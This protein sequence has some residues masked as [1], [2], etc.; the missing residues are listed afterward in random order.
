M[1]TFARAKTQAACAARALAAHGQ[2][3]RELRGTEKINS[4]GTE[5][6]TA[7]ALAGVAR[8]MQAQGWR[9]AVN[10]I[11]ARQAYHFL[12]A[13]AQ[14]VTQ[15]TLDKERRA[16]ERVLSRSLERI[17][18]T[19]QAGRLGVQ[20]R[21]YT[22]AQIEMIANAQ[23]ESNAI[24]TRLAFASGLRACEL[25][26]L[27]RVDELP[28][29][30]RARRR[31][32]LH[33]GR[34]GVVMAVVGKGGLVRH[35]VVPHD[36]VAQLEA[37][38]LDAP[39][40]VHDRGVERFQR[41]AIGAGNSWSK[42]FSDASTRVLGWSVG[43][44]TARHDFARERM[45]ELQALHRYSERDAKEIVAQEVGHWSARTTDTYLR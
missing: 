11:T 38:R 29:P 25:A 19:R 12:R 32:D 34:D 15:R 5:R 35:V 7:E 23:T 41:Y 1:R 3:R 36:L 26:T 33:A 20:Q 9:H 37:R 8:W 40:I 4:I 31:D 43:G 28:L 24:A 30:T 13:R 22:R 16:L 14:E 39:R 17:E 42:S 27:A 10:Q 6:T 45:N 21:H 44:H 18:S 2:S